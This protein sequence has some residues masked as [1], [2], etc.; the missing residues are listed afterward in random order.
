MLSEFRTRS[1][2][3]QSS[4]R[5]VERDSS[6]VAADGLNGA[7]GERPLSWFTLAPVRKGK[8]LQMVEAAEQ[9]KSVVLQARDAETK[10]SR[11]NATNDGEGDSW[12]LKLYATAAHLAVESD[13][14]VSH[15]ERV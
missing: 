5:N 15:W 12:I 2:T 14:I 8:P 1:E 13:I 11:S 9:A 7:V 10:L 3:L 6:Q 4:P